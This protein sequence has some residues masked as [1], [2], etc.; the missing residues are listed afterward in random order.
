MILMIAQEDDLCYHRCKRPIK[1]SLFGDRS[2]LHELSLVSAPSRV[3]RFVE[4]VFLILIIRRIT[5][6]RF[7][8]CRFQHN[9]AL[10]IYS[11]RSE[12]AAFVIESYQQSDRSYMDF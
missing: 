4:I 11:I 12:S 7:I 10:H 6:S 3:S 8:L 5:G 1:S 2:V 9:V